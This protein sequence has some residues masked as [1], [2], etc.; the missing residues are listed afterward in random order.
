MNVKKLK[1]KMVEKDIKA[2][3]LAEISDMSK[4]TLYRKLKTG[5][6]FSIKEANDIAKALDLDFKEVMEIFFNNFIA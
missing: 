1:A 3:Q 4:S 5:Q 2:L 6:E